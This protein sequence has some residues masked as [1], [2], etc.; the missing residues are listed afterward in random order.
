MKIF[1]LESAKNIVCKWY[2]EVHLKKWKFKTRA[3]VTTSIYKIIFF[4]KLI[5]VGIGHFLGKFGL[6]GSAGLIL[7]TIGL[8]YPSSSKALQILDF[9]F[10]TSTS[11]TFKFAHT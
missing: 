4:K 5:T 3:K 1:Q 9:T 6:L 8:K 2:E 11:K 7:S 10:S